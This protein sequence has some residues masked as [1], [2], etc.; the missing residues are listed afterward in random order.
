MPRR[1]AP[2]HI[3][4]YRSANL[5]LQE[6]GE[7]AAFFA[8]MQADECLEKGDLDCFGRTGLACLRFLSHLRSLRVITMSQK[9]S[10]MQCP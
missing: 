5:L 7:E 3:D 1:I 8:G 4:T 10:L 2:S 6:H 9:P